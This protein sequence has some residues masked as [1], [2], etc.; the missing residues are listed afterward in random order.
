MHSRVTNLRLATACLLAFATSGPCDI[1]F[2][3]DMIVSD[4]VIHLH[5]N[6]K[7]RMT[8]SERSSLHELLSEEVFHASRKS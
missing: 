8:S 5:I 7:R 3:E 6:Y 1:T 4:S 2:Q